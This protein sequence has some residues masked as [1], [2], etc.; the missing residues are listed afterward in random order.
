MT[1][2]DDDD[3]AILVGVRCEDLEFPVFN[4]IRLPCE[5]CRKETWI[6]R[7]TILSAKSH[8][9]EVIRFVCMK[10]FEPSEK[11]EVALPS[12][13]QLRELMDLDRLEAE[14]N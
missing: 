1:E 4:T 8:G 10:C 11:Y 14:R 12:V 2:N 3:V 5:E 6:S 9:H 13:G 7:E